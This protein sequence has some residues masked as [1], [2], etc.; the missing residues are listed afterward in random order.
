VSS[1]PSARKRTAPCS[2]RENESEVLPKENAY[3]LRY[4]ADVLEDGNPAMLRPVQGSGKSQVAATWENPDRY[5][6]AMPMVGGEERVQVSWLETA[7]LWLGLSAK[8]Y[9]EKLT[10][11]PSGFL[12]EINS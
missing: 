9:L 8:R 12:M 11:D 10:R 5:E 7:I 4:F 2:L 1:R 6:I 3:L